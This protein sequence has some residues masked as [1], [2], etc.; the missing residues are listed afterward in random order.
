M[1]IRFANGSVV[2]D[3]IHIG[4]TEFVLCFSLH[5]PT[6]FITAESKDG[7]SFVAEEYYTDQFAA[8]KNL[9]H[10]A[11]N[12]VHELES[13]SKSLGHREER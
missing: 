7:K 13:K 4:D 3:S 8:Q 5:P 11:M 12:K 1:D 6:R 9:C 2:L 10:R